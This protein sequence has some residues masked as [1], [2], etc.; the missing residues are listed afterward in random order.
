MSYKPA[1]EL[2]KEAQCLLDEYLSK[3]TSLK[4][5]ERQKI[6]AQE[7]PVQDPEQRSRNMAEVAL[8]YSFEQARVEAM[9]CLQCVKKNCMEGCPVKIDIP[10]FIDH[11]AKGEFEQAIA[12]VKETTLLPAVC[13]RVCPQEKQ[14]QLHCTLGKSLKD[15]DK[16]VAIGRLER[17]V[18]DWERIHNKTI[19]PAVKTSTGKKVAVIGSGPAG[20]VAAADCRREGH[21]VTIF[22]AFHK[23]GGVLRYGIP[24]FRLPNDIIDKE[25]E[26]LKAMGVEIRTNFVVG[27]TRKLTDLLEKD[28]YDAVFVGTGAGLPIFMG[29]EGENLVGVFSAN[30]YLTRAN[31]MKAFDRKADTPIYP[32]RNVVVLGGGN[33]AMDASRMAKRLGAEKVYIVYR[34]SENEMPA[35]KEEV[36]HAKEEGVEF[37]LLRNAKRILGDEQERVK[38]I[39]C[40]Q[41]ELGEPDASGRRSP[42][43]IPGSEFILDADTVIVAVGNGSNPLISQTTPQLSVS[44]RGNIIV[45]E[46]QKTSMNKI[47]A[48]GDIVLGAATV[49][50]AMGEGRKAAAAINKMLTQV[51]G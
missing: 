4:V 48:G 39:V 43:E 26:T 22:E 20:L 40:L 47:F 35:R 8:G 44:K 38:G 30:E 19:I 9:R 34:R 27:R 36:L 25:I 49:I 18:A 16:S 12:V 15:I 50:L 11:I 13:G 24:E 32:S 14:C 3:V 41:Y 10:R 21:H 33:V 45:D 51:H 28:G 6:P 2:Q 23:L 7:M 31:L 42:V 29:I 1:N 46:T 37:L 17:F 5:K